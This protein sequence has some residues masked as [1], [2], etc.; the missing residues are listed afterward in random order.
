[1][2]MK[3]TILFFILII[4]FPSAFSQSD[5]LDYKFSVGDKS[6]IITS[7][8]SLPSFDIGGKLYEK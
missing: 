6:L 3:R 8:F 4:W 2:M 1:M 5:E 7:G